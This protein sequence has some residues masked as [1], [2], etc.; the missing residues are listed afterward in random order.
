MHKKV[1]ILATSSKTRGG[2]T[3]V[4]NSCKNSSF[5]YNWNCVWIETHRDSNSIVK[6]YYLIKGLLL[7]FFN[8]STASII[9]LHLSG[10][11]SLRRKMIFIKLSKIFNK[12]IIIHYHAASPNAT[13]DSY[14]LNKYKKAFHNADHIIVLSSLWKLN[15]LK[16]LGIDENKISVVFNPCNEQKQIHYTTNNKYIL[17]AGKLNE[18][19]GYKDLIKAFSIFHK[20]KPSWKLILAG[21]GEIDEAKSLIKE[22]DL[23][24]SIQC[25]GWVSGEEK[26]NLFSR[27]SVFCL[28]SY[29]EGF[30]MAVLDAVSFGV[31][32]LTTPVGGIPDIALDNENMIL[33]NP[34]DINALSEKLVQITNE[35]ALKRLSK[36]SFDLSTNVF[37][38]LEFSN[39]INQIYNS[40]QK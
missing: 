25:V 17:Y 3:S 10:S 6:L 18:R 32:I 14:Y 39:R 1:L 29:A 38:L 28:P 22:F 5:W 15:V 31:P 8:I 19:K 12:K 36:A 30:P 27:A 20:Y 16:Q 4:I 23:E 26:Q 2:I 7:F 9:H 34:G 24:K 37:S 33:F 11:S 35:V 21:N 40:L 13:I